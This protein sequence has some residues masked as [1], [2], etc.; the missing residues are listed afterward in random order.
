MTRGAQYFAGDVVVTAATGKMIC[1]DFSDVHALFE[2]VMG[3]PV[4]THQLPRLRD[5]VRDWIYRCHP[6]L[7]NEWAAVGPNVNRENWHQWHTL[8]LR[9]HPQL[10]I[11]PM[12]ASDAPDC[13]T[14]IADAVEMVGAEKVLVVNS[15]ET[16][17]ATTGE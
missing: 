17:D 9:E 1:E 5:A 15:E 4:F 11:K 16:P 8:A 10:W 12:P 6:F 3:Q 2:V 14:P 7:F 13:S